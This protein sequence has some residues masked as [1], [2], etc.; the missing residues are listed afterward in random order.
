MDWA[1]GP[2]PQPHPARGHSRQSRGGRNAASSEPARRNGVLSNRVLAAAAKMDCK[3]PIGSSAQAASAHAIKKVFMPELSAPRGTQDFIPPATARWQELEARTHALARAFG[4]AE[5]RTPMFEST[6]LF[7]RG[8]GETKDIVEKEM[9]TF[10]DKGGRSLTL[11]PEW[12]APVVR[13]ALQHKLFAAGPQ[14]LYYVGPIFR[15]ERPQAGRYRQSH[16][17][18]VECFGYAGPEADFE[19]IQLAWQLIV[20]SGA[21]KATLRINSVGDDACRPRFREALLAYLRPRAE[22]LSETSRQRLE[23]NPLRVLDS[24]APEDLPAI[25]SAPTMESVLCEPCAAHFASLK[26]HL[27]EA[28]VPYEVDPRIVRGLDYYTRTV[29]EISSQALGAQNAVCGG[30]RYDHLVSDLGG[31][32]VPAVG[33]ALG[34]ERFLSVLEAAGATSPP[35]RAGVQ[36]VALGPEARRRLVGVLAYL[37]AR[38]ATPTYMDYDD[39]KLVAQL[40]S[41]DRNNA[42]YALIAGSQELASGELVL[43]DLVTRQDRRIPLPAQDDTAA[44]LV[45]LERS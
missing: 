21:G 36:L 29:F 14:R 23:R 28:N 41:A 27:S 19:V 30:G 10:T 34:M 9:D 3:V 7:V 45:E 4:Y 33:F 25:R 18:G 37:R 42:R 40:K 13:A 11:R 43:R 24:K 22:E 15:Y 16:Q 8:V 1:A 44:L 31:P 2:P 38:G 5:I 39:R 35:A 32:D 20:Q 12:T 17:F 26:T 6:D